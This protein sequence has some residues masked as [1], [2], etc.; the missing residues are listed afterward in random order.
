MPLTI[1][2]EILYRTDRLDAVLPR[3]KQEVSSGVNPFFGELNL[4]VRDLNGLIS[5]FNRLSD[6]KE[7]AL[8]LQ[9]IKAQF[10]NIQDGALDIYV[11][12]SPH[13][14]QQL[15]ERLYKEI[16]A[17]EKRLLKQPL[18]ASEAAATWARIH[19]EAEMS[20]VVQL[21]ETGRGSFSLGDGWSSRALGGSNSK[22]MLF[23]KIDKD[24]VTGADVVTEQYVLKLEN[25][26]NTSSGADSYLRTH[27]LSGVLTDEWPKR[28]VNYRGWVRNKQEQPVMKDITRNILWTEYCAGGDLEGQASQFQSKTLSEHLRFVVDTGKQQAEVLGIMGANGCIHMDMKNSNWLVDAAGNVR[29]ADTKGFAFTNERG[30]VD[31]GYNDRRNGTVGAGFVRSHHM[32]PSEGFDGHSTGEQ[33]HVE[34]LGRNLYQIATNCDAEDFYEDEDCYDLKPIWD[35]DFNLDI[36][37]GRNGVQLRE[38]IESSMHPNPNLR[39]SMDT[40]IQRLDRIGKGLG[41]PLPVRDTAIA[42]EGVKACTANPVRLPKE[43]PPLITDDVHHTDGS[44][45]LVI[46]SHAVKQLKQIKKSASDDTEKQ[47]IGRI[48][49]SLGSTIGA[50]S[51]PKALHTM[52]EHL[53]TQ[54]DALKKGSVNALEVEQALVQKKS[55]YKA[56]AVGGL[57]IGLTIGLGLALRSGIEMAMKYPA[58]SKGALI[59]TGGLV[60][61]GLIERAPEV[62]SALEHGSQQVLGGF[63]TRLSSLTAGDDKQDKNEVD[64]PGAGG[65]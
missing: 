55:V 6:R 41:S 1:I 25:R 21:L 44:D 28:Q 33:I 47:A 12:L 16:Q 50:L 52:R 56:A 5:K 32:N 31:S 4:K 43:S 11:S 17:E 64:R 10:K 61:F 39:P 59:T 42:Y 63:K 9:L 27:G 62:R 22:N 15:N 3:Y 2:E 20:K 49:Q 18:A 40:V 38:L 7:K 45:K 60:L 46:Y 8:Q 13:Y 29:I 19:D 34:L 23:T 35:F 54:I 57:G 48:I 24:P 51:S 26:M 30:Q 14:H 37:E 53:D 65:R 36:F 58:I